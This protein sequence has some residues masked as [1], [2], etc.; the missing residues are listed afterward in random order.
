L[1]P[2]GCAS[3]FIVVTVVVFVFLFRA[4]LANRTK[5]A[6]SRPTAL[7]AKPD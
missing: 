2:F 1:L 5:G 6:F 7:A 4:R 3:T